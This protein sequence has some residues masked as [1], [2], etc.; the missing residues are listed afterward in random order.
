MNIIPIHFRKHLVVTAVAASLMTPFSNTFAQN[1]STEERLKDLEAKIAEL[2]AEQDKAP[3]PAKEKKESKGFQVGN[4][5][6]KIGG[7]I[8]LDVHFTDTSEGE[9]SPTAAGGA[10]LDIFIPSLT[11]VDDG[12]P[13]DNSLQTDF[14]AQSSRFAIS[15]TTPTNA[16]DLSTHLELDFLISPGGNELVS[17]SFNPRLR[18]AYVDYRGFRV[19]QEW[20][21]FQ[22][23][24][25]IPESASFYTPAESQVFVRQPILRYSF[26]NFQVALENPQ[27]FIQD[28]PAGSGTIGDDGVI[29]DIIG[30]YN[31]K[32]G[33]GI[34]SLAGILRELAVETEEVDETT[35][36]IGFSIAGR[37]KVG[38]ADDI[39]FSLQAGE[40][41]GR[42]VG[43]G[44]LRGAEFDAVTGEL[45]AIG[46]VSGSFAYR[47]VSGPWS[48]NFGISLLEIDL[49]EGNVDNLDETESAQSG[50][51]AVVRKVGPKLTIAGEVLLG[52]RE[53]VDGADGEINRLTFS[54]KQLF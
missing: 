48:Y 54:V 2:E 45:D 46:S 6:V 14:T 28:P 39:R 10:G 13:G 50:Y 3:P 18:R 33:F 21:T 11:P 42:Y 35:V 49:D 25:A 24:H 47:H 1:A 20:S 8:D 40:G 29:P 41:L 23:V 19:G 31:F 7:F 36:G 16:G 53:L 26:G 30:R 44:I 15:T 9:I 4:T 5:T 12:I 32:G 43:L 52:Q 34:I 51:V 38:G 22:G 17:N 37:V 27:T